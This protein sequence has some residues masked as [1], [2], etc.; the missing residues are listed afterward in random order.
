MRP[1]KP[2][3][4]AGSV[5]VCL[6]V[7]VCVGADAA[8]TTPKKKLYKLCNNGQHSVQERSNASETADNSVRVH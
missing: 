8:E 3:G 1:A 2:W 6:C 4:V 5:Q 7:C